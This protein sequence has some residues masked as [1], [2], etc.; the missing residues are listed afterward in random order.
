MAGKRIL[1][2]KIVNK[3][4]DNVPVL[5]DVNLV[6]EEG[7]V[8][9][10]IGPSGSGKSTMLYC[11]NSLEPIQSGEIIFQGKKL[12][13]YNKLEIHESIGI[14]FQNYNLF[15]HLSVLDN[16]TLA[17]Y[18]VK[19][20]SLNQCRKK[21]IELLEKVGL[22]H[23]KDAFP[24]ELSGGQAQRIAIARS[25]AME[26]K[27]MLYDEVTS[28]L[29]P[30]LVQGVLEVIKDLVREGM[31]SLIVTHEIPFARECTD[32]CL[33]MDD[34]KIGESGP[35][36]QLLKNPKNARTKEFLEKVL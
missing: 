18:K 19:K 2:L 11:I 32:Y 20:K 33:F 31:T 13:D 27:I 17:P 34:G 29:D 26:P 6:V 21:A 9:A 12:T 28:A 1:E 30:E 22:A 4:Y 5:K 16:I 15:P 14:I 25:L 35:T 24:H 7:D 23:K 8:W 36:K 3:R 10:I